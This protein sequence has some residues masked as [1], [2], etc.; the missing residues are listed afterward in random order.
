MDYKKLEKALIDK[1]IAREFT[2]E[3]L[4]SEIKVLNIKG[5]S[6]FNKEELIKTI[7]EN[8]NK[9]K[10]ST[11]KSTIAILNTDHMNMRMS[12]NFIKFDIIKS[13]LQKSIRRGLL[14]ESLN[15]TIEGDLY[16][17]VEN[18][19]VAK[20]N[21]TNLINRLRII[22]VEDLFNWQIVN[23]VRDWF[24]KW[25]EL[26]TTDFSRKYLLSIVTAM[27]KS[28]KIR[29]LSDLKV[30]MLRD[31]YQKVIDVKNPLFEGWESKGDTELE[32]FEY[33]FKKSNFNC[34]Y[35][36]SKILDN[37]KLYNDLW[38][39]LKSDSR[40][41][42]N[43]SLLTTLNSLQILQ[44]QLTKNHKEKYLYYIF[45]VALI[46][47]ND[48]INWK[49]TKQEILF[50]DEQANQKYFEF[51][52][53]W[54]KTNLPY[55]GV[56]WLSE[57]I[58]VDKHTFT[59][60]IKG[61]TAWDFAIKGSLVE[62][63]DTNFLFKNLR[64]IYIMKKAKD[65]GIDIDNTD[66]LQNNIF[67]K[68]ILPF[69][70][71]ESITMENLKAD[72]EGFIYGQK[73]TAIWKPITYITKDWVYKGPYIG[74]REKIPQ[75]IIDRYNKFKEYGDT[76]AL[77]QEIININEKKFI[78][79][80]NIGTKW[81]PKTNIDK[82]T[83]EITGRIVERE[84]MG[85]YQGSQ[86]IENSKIEWFKCIYHFLIRYIINAG[87][88]GYWNY[89]NNYGIDYEEERSEQTQIPSNIIRVMFIKN[90]NKKFVEPTQN[91]INIYKK[92]LIEKLEKIVTED[93][94]EKKRIKLVISLLKK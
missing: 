15:Y 32:K 8:V 48:K 39:I 88:S 63:E 91:A 12:L 50:S 85:I 31:D 16:S 76:A 56:G 51:I 41:K 23:L 93:T 17:L 21:R 92:E 53:K 83:K 72:S 61:K 47:L 6:K 13:G 78:R 19:G 4:R 70:K 64:E 24:T 11:K 3:I 28:K 73:V 33:L 81:P 89:I 44:S 42:N 74:K 69:S 25:D 9:K 54:N 87:D 84:S 71:E 7:L 65:E 35:W 43:I 10:L 59:G 94:R 80:K 38:K 20:G 66:L 79:S 36:M 86:L 77:K 49:T 34:L 2:V 22:L 67:Q 1:K 29:L 46:I 27:T 18:K 90:L 75:S 30:Y 45:G 68:E 55:T 52:E 40:T 62:N 82:V 14:E 5:T 60:K 26:R 58:V 57:D 37:V